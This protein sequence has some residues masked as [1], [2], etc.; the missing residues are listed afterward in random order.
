MTK[1][2]CFSDTYND[3]KSINLQLSGFNTQFIFTFKY[4]KDISILF[5]NDHFSSLCKFC[6][7]AIKNHR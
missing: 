5:Y 2:G 4:E 1:S 7:C 3:Q 6:I